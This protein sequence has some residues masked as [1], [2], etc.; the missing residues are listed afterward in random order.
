MMRKIKYLLILVGTLMLIISLPQHVQASVGF[1]SVTFKEGDEV[2]SGGELTLYHVADV[3]Y[4]YT[5]EWNLCEILLKDVQSSLLAEQLESF[6]EE[7]Q[8][9]GE[10]FPIDETGSVKITGLEEGIYLVVQSAES[11]G[12][13]KIKSFLLTI[14]VIENGK[15]I[16]DINAFPKIEKESDKPEK[17]PSE[18]PK[19]PQEKLPQTGQLNWPIPVMAISGLILFTIGWSV[20]FTKK[21]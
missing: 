7:Q 17:E 8:I 5:A 4:K 10:R 19:N 1:L 21:E 3:A 13:C 20:R 15:M 16:Y 14:P 9:E 12:Y 11:K 2:V 6:A 18:K